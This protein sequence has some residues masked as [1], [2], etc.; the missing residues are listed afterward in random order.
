M[1]QRGQALITTKAKPCRN[2]ANG[3]CP[4]GQKCSF[5]HPVPGTVPLSSLAQYLFNWNILLPQLL[6]SSNQQQTLKNMPRRSPP[7][8]HGPQLIDE[9][10]SPPTSLLLSTSDCTS[11][12][13]MPRT[14]RLSRRKKVPCRHFIRTGGWCPAGAKCRL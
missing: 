9:D 8:P 10:P 1:D 7:P 13:Q 6:A 4:F 5:L 2:F 12:E 14:K 3:N 11:S